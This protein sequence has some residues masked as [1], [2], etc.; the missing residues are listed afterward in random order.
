MAIVGIPIAIGAQFVSDRLILLV[1]GPEFLLA[2]N[3]LKILILAASII[4][5][6]TI[7]SHAVIAIDKQRRIIKAYAFVAITALI[8]YFYFIPLYSYYGAA[9]VTIYSESAIALAAAWLVWRETGFL[10]NFSVVGKS[11]IASLF[12]SIVL[13]F[14]ADLNLL[15]LISFAIVAYFIGL[16]AVKGVTKEEIL[17]LVT[18][19]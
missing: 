18:K 16:L 7:F 3:I 5:V 1:A 13:Y 17:E 11:L 19:G 2:G 12:M 8:G 6:G 4:F 10:P 14:F 9:W 15:F